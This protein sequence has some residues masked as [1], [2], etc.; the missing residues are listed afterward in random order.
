MYKSIDFITANV[1]EMINI[2]NLEFAIFLIAERRTRKLTSAHWKIVVLQQQQQQQ[3][4]KNWKIIFT[5]KKM[6]VIVWFVK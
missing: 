1:R 5:T 6:I 4:Q 2:A 3:Q